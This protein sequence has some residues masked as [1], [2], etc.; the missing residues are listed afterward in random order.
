VTVRDDDNVAVVAFRVLLAV[1]SAA[2][3]GRFMTGFSLLLILSVCVAF[4]AFLR[5]KEK[6]K[7]LRSTRVEL[8]G[9]K[10]KFSKERFREREK[11]ARMKRRGHE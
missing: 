5:R 11:G 9:K 3:G 10:A 6:G 8:K 2:G 7:A 1:V 4:W